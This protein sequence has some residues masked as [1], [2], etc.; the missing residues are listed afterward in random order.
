MNLTICFL[1]LQLDKMNRILFGDL[2]I[3]PVISK[4]L[5]YSEYKHKYN[6]IQNY[7]YIN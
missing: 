4:Y 7:N 2:L 5:E 1:I 3:L 6:K